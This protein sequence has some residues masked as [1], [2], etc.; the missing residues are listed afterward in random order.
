[1]WTGI[2]D[3]TAGEDL[4]ATAAKIVEAMGSLVPALSRPDIEANPVLNASLG[5][6][7]K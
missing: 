7:T 5:R 3:K 6:I 1:M 2:Q 4:H